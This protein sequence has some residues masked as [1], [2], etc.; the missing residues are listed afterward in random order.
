VKR[1]FF[2]SM[3]VTVVLALAT[4]AHAQPIITAL[5][6]TNTLVTF[7]ANAPG[8]I[9]NTVTLTGNL[10]VQRIDY[11]PSD[12]QLIGFAYTA[13]LGTGEVYSISPAGVQ[14]N[15]NTNILGIG[16]ANRF[17]ADFNPTANALRITTDAASGNN[18]RIPAGG[19]GA[20]VNDT[21]LNPGTPVLRATA[22]SRNTA[23]GGINGAT[24]LYAIDGTSGNL[25]SQGSIDFF[26]GSGISPNT[27]TLTAVAAL[28]GVTASSVIGFDIFNAPGTAATSQG[29]AYLAT[30]S[31]LYTLNLVTGVATPVGTI[32]SGLTIV[33]MAVMT[34]VPEPS[35]FALCGLAA[36]G[37]AGYRRRNALKA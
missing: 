32:G 26:T 37:F 5:T 12:G 31:T 24:T 16:N 34:V 15:I 19:T 33:D 30:G 28:T 8:T 6:S 13:F 10:G 2:S 11:R 4:V 29:D 17:T 36:A 20:L 35:T 22:Y 9:L 27:G 7:S 23:G 14:T 21:A 18:L 25:V 1:F 3:A